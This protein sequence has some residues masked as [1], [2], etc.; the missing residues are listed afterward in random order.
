MSG[1]AN[2]KTLAQ[3][4]AEKEQRRQDFEAGCLLVDEVAEEYFQQYKSGRYSAETVH[5]LAKELLA[6]A[7]K[8]NRACQLV[9]HDPDSPFYRQ[10]LLEIGRLHYNIGEHAP[11]LAA[12]RLADELHVAAE[13]KGF[14]LA[15]EQEI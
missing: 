6:K 15:V 2:T 12:L 9:Q 14:V 10:I 11:A 13:R 5:D 3:L 7:A 8:A 1:Q 4:R